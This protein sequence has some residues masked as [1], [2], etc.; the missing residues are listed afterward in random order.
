MLLRFPV[1]PF[2][3]AN[4]FIVQCL[5]QA[6]GVAPDELKEAVCFHVRE[7]VPQMYVKVSILSMANNDLAFI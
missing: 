1:I 5:P 7:L 2:I 4:T 3:Y 6:S